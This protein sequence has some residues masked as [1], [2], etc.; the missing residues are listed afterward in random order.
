MSKSKNIIKALLTVFIAL[1]FIACGK[2]DNK[3]SES[4]D[5][6]KSNEVSGT[7]DN[8]KTQSSDVKTTA[9][10][11][12]ATIQLPTIQCDQCKKNITKA[13]KNVEG[14]NDFNIDVDGKV[15]TVAYD[16]SKTDLS[17]V[18]NAITAAGYDANDK[19]ADP[20]AY[21]K[22]DECC[23]VPGKK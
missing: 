6:S 12:K 16:K 21:D 9:N 18:E 8:G 1:T 10:D 2:S 3:V 17:K 15:M 19:K 22:L 14:V 20:V 13:M 11:E 4:K 7:Q 23:K 5:N